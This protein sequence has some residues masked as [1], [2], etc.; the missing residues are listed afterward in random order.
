MHESR[1]IALWTVALGCGFVGVVAML[2]NGQLSKPRSLSSSGPIATSPTPAP[3]PVQPVAAVPPAPP[4]AQPIAPLA[5]I[6]PVTVEPKVTPEVAAPA[7]PLAAIPPATPPAMVEPK[8]TPEAAEPKPEPP[9]PQRE[10][11][12]R[13]ER[14]KR[15]DDRQATQRFSVLGTE[16]PIV[17]RPPPEVAA[18]N[19]PRSVPASSGGDNPVARRYTDALNALSYEGYSGV[20]SIA[21]EGGHFRA[22][23]IMEGRRVDV[24]VDPDSGAVR[25][26][27]R[28]R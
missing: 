1:A 18:R 8:V 12:V 3:V 28:P 13:A 27:G 6:P 10:P 19:E 9:A 7:A 22:V 2:G 14:Q 16:P 17:L 20:D 24:L 21:P 23:A 15:P 4:P 26:L 25:V 11:V 5:A